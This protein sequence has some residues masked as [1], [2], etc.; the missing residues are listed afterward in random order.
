MTALFK[1]MFLFHLKRK[2]LWLLTG[3]TVIIALLAIVLS[4]YSL[5]VESLA[6]NPAV[7]SLIASYWPE[8]ETAETIG[9][10]I[11]QFNLRIF[12]YTAFFIGI[13]ILVG[14]PL[15][16]KSILQPVAGTMTGRGKILTVEI[17]ATLTVLYF[18]TAVMLFFV[19]L[20]AFLAGTASILQ[21][22]ELLFVAVK[23]S[24]LSILYFLL[25]QLT[26][27]L[28]AATTGSIFY[29]LAHFRTIFGRLSYLN[30]GIF[31]LA[32]R[33]LYIF[34]PP[35]DFLASVPAET[36]ATSLLL[37]LLHLFIIFCWIV[38]LCG[39][40]ILFSRKYDFL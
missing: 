21:L 31:G 33:G 11:Y 10:F 32:A 38:L 23:L 5:P 16:N 4:V 22:S 24:L 7:E 12:H 20:G 35:F 6:Q 1:Q 8:A 9:N 25:R 30:E 37:V 26:G 36:S 28:T 19:Q 39:G 13:M 3:L 34:L 2:K 14:S 29:I 15:D 17:I 40:I 27:F 18:F